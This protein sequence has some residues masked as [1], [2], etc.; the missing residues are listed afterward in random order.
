MVAAVHLSFFSTC[1][2][3]AAP[4]DDDLRIDLFGRLVGLLEDLRVPERVLLAVERLAGEY[5]LVGHFPSIDDTLVMGDD[6]A[7]VVLPVGEVAVGILQGG[8]AELARFGAPPGHALQ[9]PQHAETGLAIG[10]NLGVRGI[11]GPFPL[12]RLDAPPARG[13]AAIVQANPARAVGAVDLVR[14][15]VIAGGPVE[16]RLGRQSRSHRHQGLAFAGERRGRSW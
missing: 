8:V 1:P 13:N 10:G 11:P 15:R 7:D 2:P 4:D 16:R 12:C 5:R 3:P 6:G 14:P 9:E